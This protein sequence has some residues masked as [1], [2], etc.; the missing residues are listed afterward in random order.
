MKILDVLNEEAQ[1]KNL[2]LYSIS[3]LRGDIECQN[4][5]NQEIKDR[6]NLTDEA[7]NTLAKLPEKDI[8]VG[9]L[10]NT[11]KM[12]KHVD[13]ANTIIADEDLYTTFQTESTKVISKIL[14]EY[15]TQTITYQDIVKV[16]EI[17]SS[18]RKS[19]V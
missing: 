10:F 2:P 18:D 11:P 12:I 3:Y 13:I 14:T 1:K 16:L 19:V 8:D 15:P 5:S 17:Y 4:I 7:I 6:T 9:P